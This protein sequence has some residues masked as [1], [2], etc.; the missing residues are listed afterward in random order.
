[1]PPVITSIAAFKQNITGGAF[2]ALAAATKDSLSIISFPD[3]NQAYVEEIFAN[4]SANK[5][6]LADLLAALR[7]QHL[8]P[9]A[10]AHVQPDALGRRRQQQLPRATSTFRSGRDRHAQRAGQRHRDQQRRRRPAALLREHPGRRPAA[11][12]GAGHSARSRWAGGNS[13][14][15]GIEVTVTPGATGNYGTA[16]ALNANDDRLQADYDYALLGYTSDQPVLSI[17]IRARTPASTASRCPATWDERWTADWF[18]QQSMDRGTPHIPSS[19]PTT[20]RT[21]FLDGIDA[22][23]PGATKVSLIF[24]QLAS[25][26]LG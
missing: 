12:P 23:N 10:A 11:R 19:T 13:R 21:T 18:L 15:L 1:M 4:N 20:R 6:E 17:G 2:E 9:A 3:A 8:R 24:A 26:F 16:V 5:M 7:R 22:A 25:K 14:V